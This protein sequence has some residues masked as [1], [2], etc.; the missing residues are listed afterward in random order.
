KRT[1]RRL[2]LRSCSHSA[3]ELNAPRKSV[4]LTQKKAAAHSI[5]KKKVVSRRARP[6]SRMTGSETG[7]ALNAFTPSR[8][9]PSVGAA[10][11][12]N[13]HVNRPHRRPPRRMPRI[14]AALSHPR[15]LRVR[16]LSF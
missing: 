7:A 10:L 8:R 12:V 5:F 3:K 11:V 4:D 15:V 14:L 9:T 16:R 13:A 6:E 1:S 2:R